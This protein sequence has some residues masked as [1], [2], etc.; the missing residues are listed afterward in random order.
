[1]FR[2]IEITKP[3]LPDQRGPNTIDLRAILQ[4]RDN[5][6]ATSHKMMYKTIDSQDLKLKSENRSVKSVCRWKWLHNGDEEFIANLYQF[7]ACDWSFSDTIVP[8]TIPIC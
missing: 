2:F 1:M 4:K 8:L 5:S 3:L 7:N 6:R